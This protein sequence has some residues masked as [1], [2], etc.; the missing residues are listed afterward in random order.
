MVSGVFW[1]NEQNTRRQSNTTNSEYNPTVDPNN[2]GLKIDN[3]YFSLIPGK[4]YIYE[5][6]TEDGKERIE[7]EVTNEKRK[8]MG[9]EV[10]TVRDRVYLNNLL[11]EDTKDWYAQDREGNVWYFGEMVDNYENGVLKDHVGSWEA[12]VNEAKPGI[13]M[14][15][16][17][18][19][20]DQYFQEYYK[21]EAE[22]MGEVVAINQ[23][24]NLPIGNFND[25]I[26]TRDWS[27]IDPNL[28][29]YK[30]YCDQIG[31]M[32]LERPVDGNESGTKLVEIING[33]SK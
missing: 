8:V 33:I 16:N 12:G 14:K 32:G 1:I 28:N 19:V 24:I 17:P 10:T 27:R 4:K 22:D 13:I 2:F 20:G 7:V 25:C 30:Y 15:A 31:F 6:D 29:E 5:K 26:Q 21:G 18:V 3:K 9:V 11:I 23:N